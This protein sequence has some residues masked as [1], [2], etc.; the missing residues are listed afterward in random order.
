MDRRAKIIGLLLQSVNL[1]NEIEKQ[2]KSYGTDE[3]LYNSEIDTLMVIGTAGSI[4]LTGI[5]RDLEIS[6]SGTSRFVKKLLDKKMIWKGKK[7]GNDKEVI[8]V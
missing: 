4:N 1:F 3:L 8:L 5:A 6:K 7:E 2:P